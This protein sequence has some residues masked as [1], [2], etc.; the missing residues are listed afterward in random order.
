MI[1]RLQITRSKFGPV[2]LDGGIDSRQ[3]L[4]SLAGEFMCCRMLKRVLDKVLQTVTQSELGQ[5]RSC[6][7]T[8]VVFLHFA[9][10][11]EKEVATNAVCYCSRDL[12][13]VVAESTA[14]LVF[15]FIVLDNYAF[16][17][18]KDG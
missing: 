2:N 1:A 10:A 11:K 17:L 16:E 15:C 18:Y 3:N 7:F 8:D 5:P 12:L 14:V 4:F 9:C 6:I 13:W